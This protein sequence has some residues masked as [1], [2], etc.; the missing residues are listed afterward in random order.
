MKSR[1]G[2]KVGLS[3]HTLGISA[4]IAA[5][6]LGARV[7]EKHF[8]LDKKLG[9][10]DAAFS[11]E[12]KEFKAMVSSI[13]EVEKALGKVTYE[14]SEKVEKSRIFARSLF[15]VKDIKAGDFLTNDNIRSI[16]PG[17]GLHPKY[18]KS[19]LGKKAKYDLAK[20]TPLKLE[21]ITE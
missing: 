21:F 5:V 17:Y 8:I 10:P 12:P 18:L 3:D 20:G 2:V 14:I 4:P 16:R 1:F 6:S 13:R 9:G 11:L 7:I 19:V 15:V